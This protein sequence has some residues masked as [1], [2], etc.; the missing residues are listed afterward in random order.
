L[1]FGEEAEFL[2]ARF[3]VAQ[4]FCPV[5]IHV[6]LRIAFQRGLHA[7]AADVRAV[8]SVRRRVAVRRKYVC[9][10]SRRLLRFECCGLAAFVGKLR[11]PVSNFLALIVIFIVSLQ[12]L[13]L[14]LYVVTKLSVIFSWDFCILIFLSIL[15]LC[16]HAPRPGGQV[17]VGLCQ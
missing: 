17:G 14:S 7:A 9:I 6:C 15:F 11:D 16:A 10:G 3:R 1:T 8:M 12:F 2:P 4:F 13:V 5:F